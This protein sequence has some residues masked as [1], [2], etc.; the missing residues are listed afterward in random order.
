MLPGNPCGLA[1]RACKKLG[2]SRKVLRPQRLDVDGAPALCW[3]LQ[4]RRA[5]CSPSPSWLACL[6][7]SVLP[8]GLEQEGTS[9]G[10][11]LVALPKD[12][13]TC[14]R[15]CLLGSPVLDQSVGHTKTQTQLPRGPTSAVRQ[16]HNR[17]EAPHLHCDRNT[18]AQRPHICTVTTCLPPLELWPWA[19]QLP[20]REPPVLL[21]VGHRTQ[22][23]L[24]FHRQGDGCT[25][26]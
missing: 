4:V 22:P 26:W 19:R 12:S 18:T 6:C 20:Y 7:S 13:G 21:P 1:K 24:S 15:G 8:L 14:L 3:D 5:V 17:P 11:E 25:R 16:K 9:S 2:H 10:A 23:R